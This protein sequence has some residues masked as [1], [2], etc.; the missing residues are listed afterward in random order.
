MPYPVRLVDHKSEWSAHF[1]KEK[2]LI[3]DI[4]C[5][6]NIVVEHIGSTSIPGI[7]AKS[8]ID[9]LV[10]VQTLEE[11]MKIIP[12]LEKIGYEYFPEYEERIPERRYL[13]KGEKGK[14]SHH[15]HMF[16]IKSDLWKEHLLFR[17]YL[18]KNKEKAKEYEKLKVNLAKKYHSNKEE[19]TRAKGPFIEKMIR[20]ART[21]ISYNNK[22]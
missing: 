5:I 21:Q 6:K 11:A 12:D 1:E 20:E 15:L 16:D 19:Y 17:E 18:R 4:V 10:G 22:F 13:S 3:M 14:R 8:T 2:D 7:K 9:I